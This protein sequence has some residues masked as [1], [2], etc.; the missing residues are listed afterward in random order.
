MFLFFYLLYNTFERKVYDDS[1]TAWCA[2]LK[3][4]IIFMI[5]LIMSDNLAIGGITNMLS[6][7]F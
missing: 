3:D 6:I 4:L 5:I 7:V 1:Y 2:R